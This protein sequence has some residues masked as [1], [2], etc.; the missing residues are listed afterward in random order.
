MKGL[1]SPRANAPTPKKGLSAFGGVGAAASVLLPSA[2]LMKEKSVRPN[3]NI[4]TMDATAEPVNKLS[5]VQDLESVLEC[6]TIKDEVSVR[7]PAEAPN[8]SVV[9]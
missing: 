6:D 9:F 1:E 8:N 2:F 4:N 7:T 3:L 5:V